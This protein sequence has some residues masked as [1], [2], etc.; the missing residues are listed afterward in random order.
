MWQSCDRGVNCSGLACWGAG[1]PYAFCIHPMK[2]ANPPIQSPASRGGPEIE[3]KLALPLSL[4]ASL[5]QRLAKLPAL[6]GCR[7]GR[8]RVHSIYYDTPQ[9]H[10]YR[11][12]QIL[13]VRMTGTPRKPRWVQTFKLGPLVASALSR[14]GEWQAPISGSTPSWSALLD[15]PWVEF[16]PDGRLFH[17]L[18]PRFATRFTRTS[19]QVTTPKGSQIVVALDIGEIV[20][21]HLRTPLCE[22]ELELQQGEVSDVLALA[23]QVA[24]V[25][26]VLPLPLSKAERGYA[27][28][29]DA[30][31]QP[32]PGRPVEL[33]VDATL[34]EAVPQVLGQAYAQ[35][36]SNLYLLRSSDAP[37]LVHQARVGW[38]RFRAALRLFKPLLIEQM[39]PC[40]QPLASLLQP[41]GELRDLE[42]ALND[43]L[44]PLSA[45]YARAHPGRQANWLAMLQT[46]AQQAR[47]R[48]QAVRRA[49]S[50]PAVGACLLALAVWLEQWQPAVPR[51]KASAE[52]LRD[53]ARRR[54]R[55]LHEQL[56]AACQ[57]AQDAQSWHRVRIQ[58]KRLRYSIEFLR[59][60]LPEPRAQRWYRQ[61]TDWQSRLGAARDIQ[62][63]V[64]L[65]QELQVDA[66]IA[67]YLQ[68]VAAKAG[69]L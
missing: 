60:L 20:A 46:L 24:E 31:S 14:R 13:R 3:L 26:A 52:P 28:A 39:P 59:P 32:I 17:A 36:L 35:F 55:R 8:Q 47:Q 45:R 38:R 1:W 56:A 25:V 64:L 4:A 57:V 58:A 49:L 65:A 68:R 41:L 67:A 33:A 48:R 66:D 22:L 23:R 16:D 2:T 43:T 10:L 40:W 63:T 37:E 44:P 69:R 21:G 11:Q 53:W 29:A 54:I 42:V 19:W 6:A 50:R 7:P 34:A 27:L 62:Q 30:L 18:A 61:A 12:Q 51:D 9:L 5:A 15:S